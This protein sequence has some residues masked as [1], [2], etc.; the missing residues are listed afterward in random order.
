M[1]PRPPRGYGS[2]GATDRVAQARRARPRSGPGR[3]C[4][5]SACR[6]LYYD[7]YYD[8]GCRS[9]FHVPFLSEPTRSITRPGHARATNENT[10]AELVHIGVK[11]VERVPDGDELERRPFVVAASAV[12]AFPHIVVVDFSC[13]TDTKL[14]GD[15]RNATRAALTGRRPPLRRA[16][17][18]RR[19]RH[20]RQQPRL[21]GALQL[22]HSACGDL[23]P[24]RA[25][26]T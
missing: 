13:V 21:P 7:T 14:L 5:C 2:S 19:G 17:H 12:G 15:E 3:R 24:C 25:S 26:S 6:Q 9:I 1:S 18:T 16:R 22:L 20:D 8:M 11:K 23:P 4:R 10:P